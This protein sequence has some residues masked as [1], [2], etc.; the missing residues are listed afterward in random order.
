M[1]KKSSDRRQQEALEGAF[2][3]I[4]FFLY[5]FI[6]SKVVFYYS[7]YTILIS[8]K[9]Q[10][11]DINGDGVLSVDEYYR[12]LKEHGIQCS[13]DEILQIIQIADKDHDG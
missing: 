13:R 9:F 5:S 3:V 12:I 2:K 6:I 11:A 7:K 1:L 10:K 4:K 8:K